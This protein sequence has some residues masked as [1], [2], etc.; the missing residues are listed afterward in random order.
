MNHAH[1]TDHWAGAITRIR[2]LAVADPFA[3]SVRRRTPGSDGELRR[4]CPEAYQYPGSL[5]AAAGLHVSLV[6]PGY[7]YRL[8]S[9]GA[10]QFLTL[11]Q[12]ASE[13]KSALASKT[14]V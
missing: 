8:N 3:R 7:Y 10:V 5:L 1:A 11:A 12:A 4:A 2:E 14:N 9:S 13:V 6:F